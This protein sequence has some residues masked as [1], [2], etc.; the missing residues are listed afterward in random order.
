MDVSLF[1]CNFVSNVLPAIPGELLQSPS[2]A[3]TRPSTMTFDQIQQFFL[4]FN[5]F[6]S[7]QKDQ[8]I[9][10]YKEKCSALFPQYFSKPDQ[11]KSEIR[12][13]KYSL[14]DQLCKDLI[15]ELYA[16]AL[17]T[18][19]VHASQ[20]VLNT[21]DT[22]PNATEKLIFI[23]GKPPQFHATKTFPTPVKKADLEP[24][25]PEPS[26]EEPTSLTRYYKT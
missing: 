5:T 14:I 6:Y 7:V 12:S 2:F 17:R 24:T 1:I 11:L 22:L 26:K 25:S 13:L 8:V 9:T 3:V 18:Q 15:S 21:L 23:I 10:K 4:F 16:Y 20:S 19:I